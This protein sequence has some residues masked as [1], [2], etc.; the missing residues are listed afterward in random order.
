LNSHP[1]E[2]MDSLRRL[3]Y[4]VQKTR[5]VAGGNFAGLDV[6]QSSI[7][8]L[9][10]QAFMGEVL[11]LDRMTAVLQAM[12]KGIGD[13]AAR[14]AETDLSRLALAQR[15][16]YRGLC[17]A[18]CEGLSAAGLAYTECM[19]LN[20]AVVS[21]DF[22]KAIA[23]ETRELKQQVDQIINFADWSS[24]TQITLLQTHCFDQLGNVETS[25][26]KSSTGYELPWSSRF[27]RLCGYGPTVEKNETQANL[28]LLGL[29]TNGALTGLHNCQPAG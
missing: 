11:T 24:N 17:R 15:E 2:K 10:M 9:A 4:L 3:L 29:I 1:G 26:P 14:S 7:Y 6:L 21:A 16:A 27:F 28:M 22:K 12:Q 23:H 20:G 13:S 18:A 19:K 25:N 8:A 5:E